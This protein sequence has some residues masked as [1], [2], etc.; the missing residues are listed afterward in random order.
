MIRQLLV[1]GASGDLA[2]RSLLPALARL[3]EAGRLPELL[4]VVGV[5]CDDWDTA[6]F[7]RYITARLERHAPTVHP[8]A[9]EAVAALASY[10]RADAGDAAAL[11][12]AVDQAKVLL[13]PTSPSRRPRSRP[14]S[15]RS[16]WSGSPTAAAWSSRSRSGGA[17]ARRVS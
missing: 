9:W 8:A 3:Y 11:A 5:A 4:T 6:A 17:S 10:H 2:G 13:S 15:R 7:R 16:P 14:P 12:G 1:L